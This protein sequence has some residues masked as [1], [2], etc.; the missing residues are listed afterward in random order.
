MKVKVDWHLKEGIGRLMA[1][2]L[3]I[4][5][6]ARDPSMSHFFKLGTYRKYYQA[7]QYL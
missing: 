4:H 7:F 1:L 5:Q 6:K 2:G 3:R